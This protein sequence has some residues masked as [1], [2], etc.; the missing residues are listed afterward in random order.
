MN[1]VDVRRIKA[2]MTLHGYTLDTLARE[3]GISSKTLSTKLN[4]CPEKLTQE[5]IEKLVTILKIDNPMAIF[6]NQWLRI[7]KQGGHN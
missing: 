7:T 5:Q 4:K 2:Q 6:F 1:S 3:L